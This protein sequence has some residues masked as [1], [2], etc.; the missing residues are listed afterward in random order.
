VVEASLANSFT[1][2]AKFE[3]TAD[4]LGIFSIKA[5]GGATVSGKDKITLAP[6]TGLAYLL[7]DLNWNKDKTKV[8]KTKVDEWS[9][10]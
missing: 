8:E 5:S 6:G 10:N 9:L 2:G 4:A 7:L 1:A 3:V